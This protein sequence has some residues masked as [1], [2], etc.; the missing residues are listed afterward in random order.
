[1][2][3]SL[4]KFILDD[5]HIVIVVNNQRIG[6]IVNIFVQS[7]CPTSPRTGTAC[8]T[9][10]RHFYLT[11]HIWLIKFLFFRYFYEWMFRFCCRW[12]LLLYACFTF[13]F[14]A[15]MLLQE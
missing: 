3:L 11:F 12:F 8:F 14:P 1:M 6:R 2:H 10:P 9:V 7:G 4:G 5:N 13:K 15:L